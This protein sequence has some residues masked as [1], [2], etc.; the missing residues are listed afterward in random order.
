MA[1]KAKPKIVS[2]TLTA[3]GFYHHMSDKEILQMD[4]IIE[5]DGSLP[6]RLEREP[7]NEVDPNA[8]KII[9]LDPKNKLF[10]NV[11][12]AYVGRPANKPLVQLLKRGAT[13]K[14]CLLVYIDLECGE[15]DLEVK[16]IRPASKIPANGKIT[17]ASKK[18]LTN[19]DG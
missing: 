4:Q 10:T 16:L 1:K 14:L 2:L 17:K 15:G 5:E 9:A 6:C 18:S 11:H 12:I 13:I 3:R 7:D 8:V 19:P